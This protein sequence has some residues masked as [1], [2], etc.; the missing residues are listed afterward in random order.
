MLTP[1]RPAQHPEIK[2]PHPAAKNEGR[3]G[4]PVS[5][6]VIPNHLRV[7]LLPAA[8]FTA[9]ARLLRLPIGCGMEV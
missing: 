1:L 8:A 2:D 5:V 3:I 4:A 9:I 7:K 6:K